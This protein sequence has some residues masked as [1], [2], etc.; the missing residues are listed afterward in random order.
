MDHRYTQLAFCVC[1]YL[2]ED[3]SNENI[4]NYESLSTKSDLLDF[5]YDKNIAGVLIQFATPVPSNFSFYDDG[6]FSSCAP[7]WG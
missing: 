3:Y 7:S 5:I 6:E 2:G 4:S 1:V